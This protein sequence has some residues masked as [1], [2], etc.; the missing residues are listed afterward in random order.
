V[1]ALGGSISVEHGVG[2]LKRD[3]LA[4]RK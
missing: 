2:A 1:G 3:E 4:E